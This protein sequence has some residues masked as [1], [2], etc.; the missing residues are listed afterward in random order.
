MPLSLYVMDRKT[1][2][3]S[4]ILYVSCELDF[5]FKFE[6][7]L[8]IHWLNLCNTVDKQGYEEKLHVEVAGNK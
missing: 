3:I 4:K 1:K 7:N 2:R 6:V 5:F 8:F